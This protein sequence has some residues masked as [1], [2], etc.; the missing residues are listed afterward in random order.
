M[1]LSIIAAMD[2][3]RG[4]GFQN[5]LPWNIPSDLKRFRAITL[6]HD[7]IMG[8]KTFQSIGKPLPLRTN[9][10]LSHNTE[11][12]DTLPAEQ[13]EQLH[14]IPLEQVRTQFEHAAVEAF[15]IGGSQI[16]EQLLPFCQKLY[17]T[18]IQSA[19][20]TDALFPEFESQFYCIEHA[21]FSDPIAHHFKTY[22]RNATVPL[23]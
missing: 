20:Q 4:I 15:V 8:R 2:I 6:H 14:Q 9:W 22:L 23:S 21:F 1:S 16:Y 12:L 7:V 3:H 5:R 10:I 19:F 11:W 18:H 17:L 13:Q